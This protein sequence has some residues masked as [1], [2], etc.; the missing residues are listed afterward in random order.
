MKN[1]FPI[2]GGWLV[3]SRLRLKFIIIFVAIAVLPMLFLGSIS[4]YLL[5]DSHAKDVSALETQLIDQKTE[6]ISKFFADTLNIMELKVSFTQRSVIAPAEQ[7]FILDGLFSE[8]A[9][10]R[11]VSLIDLSGTETAKRERGVLRPKLK[12]VS[13]L[14]Y[15]ISAKDGHK[16]VSEVYQMAEGPAM[17]IAA[18]VVNRNGDIVQIL[19]AEVSLQ[20]LA[21]SIAN[22]RVGYSGTLYVTD[23]SGRIIAGRYF[24]KD[25]R[26]TDISGDRRVGAVLGGKSFLGSLPEDRFQSALLKEPVV[27]AGKKID[28]P[29]WGVFVEWPI[30][31]A[32]AV[33]ND[34]RGQVMSFAWTAILIMLLLAPLLAARFTR[35]IE[36]LK[37]GAKRIEKGDFTKKLDIRTEDEFEELG[38]S[39][40]QMAIGLARLQELRNEFVYLVTH[41]LRSPVTVIRG[42]LSMVREGSL[43][44]ITGKV[45][46][47]IERLWQ[48]SDYLG[49]LIDDLLD[50]AKLEAGQMKFDLAP[51][52]V[53]N[54]CRIVLADM[55]NYSAESKIN[56]IVPAEEAVFVKADEL[57]LKQVVTNLVSNGIKYNRPGGELRVSLKTQ[58]G[59]VSV[60]FADTG[61]GISPEDQKR[62][63]E[64]FFRAG[65]TKTVKGTGLGLFITKQFME[66][67][68]GSISVASVLEKG[69]TFTITLD[70]A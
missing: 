19:A 8:N 30:A 46:E 42:M 60:L 7:G 25:F 14:P 55:A 12:N 70:A 40:N 9:S 66:A 64:K 44:P 69:T 61:K 37:T 50:V 32:D 57:R 23:S 6:E 22:S 15:F 36:E 31:D 24:G 65:A 4:L 63:F 20:S 1:Y 43:G 26:G 62:L 67:M 29:D 48:S 27:G 35:A 52:D 53:G 56:L 11:E 68:S 47:A 3:G 5:S 34:V 54:L 41:E 38:N 10:F 21:A 51:V 39:F 33:L 59:R 45:V 13:L 2:I 49:D 18:P 16:Y 28:G 17:T 58:A